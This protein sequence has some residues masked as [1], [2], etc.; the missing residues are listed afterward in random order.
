MTDTRIVLKD[1]SSVLP[2][3]RQLFSNLNEQFDSRP[4]GLVGR[5][6]I[7]KTLLARILAGQLPPTS[8]QCLHAGS[9]HYLSQQP[10]P[11]DDSTLADLAGVKQTL[12]ALQ[13]IQAGS[14]APKDFDAVGD[15]WDMHQRMHEAVQAVAT[16]TPIAVHVVPEP[17]RSRRTLAE[18]IDVKLPYLPDIS[19]LIN[20]IL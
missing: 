14:A 7:G 11:Q 2:D 16:E 19:G 5:N 10:L 13:R 17:G 18:L 1:L 6:G 15:G 3:G 12:D 8:G 9:V 20:L 4:T